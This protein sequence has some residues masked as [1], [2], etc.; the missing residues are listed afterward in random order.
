MSA[1][2]GASQARMSLEIMVTVFSQPSS[3]TK[4]YKKNDTS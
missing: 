2:S 1:F 3:L 4:L